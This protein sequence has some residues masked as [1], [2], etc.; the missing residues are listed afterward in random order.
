MASTTSTIPAF[1]DALIAAV[2]FALPDVQVFDGAPTM[3]IPGDVVL[4]GFTGTPGES[5]VVDVRTRTQYESSPDQESYEVTSLCS[6]WQG[7]DTDAKAVRDRAFQL[8]DQGFT[9]PLAADPRLG[10]TVARA[11]VTATAFSAYQTV[12]GAVATVLVTV[13]VDAWT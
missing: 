8:V 7:A 10:K 11:R 13:H 3:E 2:T 6:S 1:L 12:D 4:V 9:A 5:A